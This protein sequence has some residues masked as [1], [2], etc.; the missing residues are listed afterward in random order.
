[1]G[2]TS[3]DRGHSVIEAIIRSQKQLMTPIRVDSHRPQWMNLTHEAVK[4]PVHPPVSKP[5]KES[6]YN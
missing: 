5:L 1:M 4:P 2:R 6:E 3:K